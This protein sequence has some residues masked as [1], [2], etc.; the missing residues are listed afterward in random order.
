M[1]EKK[2]IS[3]RVLKWGPCVIAF[4]AEKEF[5]DKLLDEAKGSQDSYGDRLAGHLKKEMKL[6]AMNYKKYFDRMFTVYD[7]ALQGWNRKKGYAS[8]SGTHFSVLMFLTFF[9]HN[10]WNF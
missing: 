2:E 6:N 1:K 9:S 3:Y 5:T 4:K 10:L 7:H 8:G